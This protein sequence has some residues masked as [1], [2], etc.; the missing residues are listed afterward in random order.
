MHKYRVY[1]KNGSVLIIKAVEWIGNENQI[2]FFDENDEEVGRIETSE[3]AAMV[4]K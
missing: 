1:L 4:K 3:L 2:L